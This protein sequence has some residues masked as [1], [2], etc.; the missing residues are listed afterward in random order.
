MEWGMDER[1][2]KGKKVPRQ[3]LQGDLENQGGGED[4]CLH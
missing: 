1:V 4:I 2:S 3:A